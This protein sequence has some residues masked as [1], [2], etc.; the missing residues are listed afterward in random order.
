MWFVLLKVFFFFQ[1]TTMEAQPLIFIHSILLTFKTIFV[2]IASLFQDFVCCYKDQT[3]T[4]IVVSSMIQYLKT[5][6]I[7]KLKKY[8]YLPPQEVSKASL[9]QVGIFLIKSMKEF[10]LYWEKWRT[11]D[12][13][14]G[15]L[16]I[17]IMHLL[18]FGF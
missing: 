8:N 17:N 15:I 6:N 3:L 14:W 4:N 9:K 13:I 11:M 16:P 1:N 18:K 12:I 5:N 7:L 10:N 2:K